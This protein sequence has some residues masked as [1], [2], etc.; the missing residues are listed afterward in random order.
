M[1]AAEGKEGSFKDPVCS[2]QR[3][4]HPAGSLEE[5]LM[6]PGMTEQ[7]QDCCKLILDWRKI[8]LLWSCSPRAG[9]NSPGL[10]PGILLMT[11]AFVCQGLE[12]TSLS[13]E[14]LFVSLFFSIIS[15]SC[16][17]QEQFV[18]SSVYTLA[19]SSSPNC[20]ACPLRSAGEVAP[21]EQP[22]QKKIQRFFFYVF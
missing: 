21:W 12:G 1:W 18:T 14:N 4:L 15:A 2:N 9:L 16:L 3:T 8:F 7:H 20:N 5:H 22:T 17:D 11:W 10:F 19:T 6:L 13:V